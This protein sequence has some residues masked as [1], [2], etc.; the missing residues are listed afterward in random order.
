MIFN[1][2]LAGLGVAGAMLAWSLSATLSGPAQALASRAIADFNFDGY[3]DLV[4]ASPLEDVGGVQEAGVVRIFYGGNDG[5]GSGGLQTITQS[6]GNLGSDPEP[7][8]HFGAAIAVGD[9]LFGSGS[10]LVIGV[11]DEDDDEIAGNRTDSGL[12]HILTGGTGVQLN[13]NAALTLNQAGAQLGLAEVEAGD[14]WGAALAVGR[15]GRSGSDLAVGAP[16]ED[17]QV[18]DAGAV[19]L[20]HFESSRFDGVRRLHQ[21][22]TFVEGEA[23][24]GDG[25]GAAVAMGNFDNDAFDDVAV[26]VPANQANSLDPGGEVNVFYGGNPLGFG[27]DQLWRQNMLAGGREAEDDFGASLAVGSF[28][29]GSSDDLA[30]GVPGENG[31]AG[32][33]AVV[34]GTSAGLSPARNQLWRQGAGGLSDMAESGDRFGEALAAGNYNGDGQDD[35]AI[36]VPRESNAGA[37]HAIYG[38]SDG[39][40]SPGQPAL[41]SDH[42]DFFVQASVGATG[43]QGDRFGAAL[44]AGDYDDNNEADLSIGNPAEDVDGATG[45]DHGQVIVVFGKNPLIGF[46]GLDKNDHRLF[47]RPAFPQAG[48]QFGAV[49]H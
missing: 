36:G 18:V 20:L 2:R 49:L 32:A 3:D 25:F 48:G 19:D 12:V 30:I 46:G 28:D 47:Q 24:A 45:A 17:I 26:G 14:R 38:E 1:R 31:D 42:E 6:S 10:E 39:P 44:A 23:A 22:E 29:G 7:G 37:V 13:V 16:G 9:F 27:D 41:G 34:Y 40:Q 5:P 8:D 15:V 21:D 43:E 33:V 35:L 4:V 11:P